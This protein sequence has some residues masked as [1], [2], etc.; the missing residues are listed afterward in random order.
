MIGVE[1]PSTV[2]GGPVIATV[3]VAADVTYQ[4]GVYAD[5]SPFAALVATAQPQWSPWTHSPDWKCASCSDPVFHTS[6][7][8]NARDAS[9]HQNVVERIGSVRE[10][11]QAC[12]TSPGP[13]GRCSH[14]KVAPAARSA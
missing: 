11:A 8:S 9:F 7:P 6:E 12:W 4:F 13:V 10:N 2:V 3:G 5:S 14:L 1:L